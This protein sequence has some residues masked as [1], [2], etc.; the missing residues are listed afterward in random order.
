MHVNVSPLSG[1]GMPVFPRREVKG[2]GMSRWVESGTLERTKRSLLMFRGSS[3]RY[4]MVWKKSTDMISATLQHDV[5]CLEGRRQ[6]RESDQG[7]D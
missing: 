3:G 6:D 4:F 2:L 5:G 1:P 7:S